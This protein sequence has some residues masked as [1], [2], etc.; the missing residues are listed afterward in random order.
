MKKLPKKSTI[1]AKIDK[2]V[3][4]LCRAV[5]HCERCGSTETLQ[6]CHISSRAYL[7]TRWMFENYLCLCAACHFWMHKN[8]TLFSEWFNSVFPGRS[9]KI[10]EALQKGETWDVHRMLKFLASL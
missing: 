2:L 10:H 3:G 8:P 4:A 5:G 7:S 6:W 1:K 9:K